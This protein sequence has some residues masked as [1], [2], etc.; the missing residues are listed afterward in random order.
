MNQ[1]TTQYLFGEFVA[2]NVKKYFMAFYCA[3]IFRKNKKSL[4][5]K[6]KINLQHLNKVT[7]MSMNLHHGPERYKCNEGV[8]VSKRWTNEK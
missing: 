5:L 6:A 4:T 3:V 2:C 7:T 8:M 1:Y